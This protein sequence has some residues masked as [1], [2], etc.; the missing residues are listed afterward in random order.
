MGR[1]CRK[2]NKMN[3]RDWY[4]KHIKVLA[5]LVIIILGVLIINILILPSDVSYDVK[6]IV[7]IVDKY[8]D[9]RETTTLYR[10]GVIISRKTILLP[11]KYVAPDKSKKKELIDLLSKGPKIEF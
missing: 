2:G 5:T 7:T 9:I 8:G 4:Q 6:Q 1:T 11:Y 10:R 3:I